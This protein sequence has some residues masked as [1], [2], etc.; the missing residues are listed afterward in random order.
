MTHQVITFRFWARA[1]GGLAEPA[2]AYGG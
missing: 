2:H 1:S